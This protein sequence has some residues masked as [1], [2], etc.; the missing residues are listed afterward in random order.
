[1][2]AEK[3]MKRG[4]AN[5]RGVLGRAEWKSDQAWVENTFHM[6]GK[7]LG[8]TP[9]HRGLPSAR[10]SYVTIHKNLWNLQQTHMTYL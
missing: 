4:G 3:G 2:G 6:S 9:E 7:K 10:L 8:R 5:R 1:M